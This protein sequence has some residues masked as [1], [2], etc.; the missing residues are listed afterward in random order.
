MRHG[1]ASR[2]A[3]WAAAAALSATLAGCAAGKPA[4]PPMPD[5]STN[6]ARAAAPAPPS[7]DGEQLKDGETLRQFYASVE[8]HLT[9][10]GRLRREAAPADAPYS[11]DDLVRDFDNIALK[12]EYTDLNGSY[13]HVERPALLRRWEK[14]VR[15][16]V[17]SG[18]SMSPE[19]A[20]R[21]RANVAAFTRRLAH[22]TGR[23]V[24]MGQGGDVNFLVVFMDSAERPVVAEQVKA[25]YP[26]VAPSAATALRDTPVDIFCANYATFDPQAPSTY[27]TVVVLIRAEHPPLTRLSCVNEEMAQSMGLPNDSSLARPSLFNDSLEFALLTEHDAVLLRMLYDPRLRAGMSADE[28][29]PL[30]PQIAAD[31]R[32]AQLRDER[33]MVVA[34]AN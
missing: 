16:G 11:N 5:A 19:E 8:D 28:I 25:L 13:T 23:D 30:L 17:I 12:D 10:N 14:P 4:E 3:S 20:A 22:L 33:T 18:A 15:V 31:A 6:L 27:A 9:A 29:R 24:A 21:D 2:A 34:E 1:R 7:L 26:G 32:Q